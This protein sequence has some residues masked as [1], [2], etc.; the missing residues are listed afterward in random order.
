MSYRMCTSA[1]TA[2]YVNDSDEQTRKVHVAYLW[3]A[4]AVSAESKQF[5][6][7]VGDKGSGPGTHARQISFAVPPGPQFPSLSA[8]RHKSL[9]SS[10]STAGKRSDE[11]IETSG[12]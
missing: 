11:S 5:G 6:L 10:L 9:V 8:P 12:I 7:V 1:L 3:T 4:G 2:V